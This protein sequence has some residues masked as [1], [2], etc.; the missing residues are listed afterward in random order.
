[1]NNEKP[2]DSQQTDL[3]S[4]AESLKIEDQKE[5]GDSVKSDKVKSMHV[6]T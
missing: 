1:M 3:S 6:L 5:N 4:A 2:D